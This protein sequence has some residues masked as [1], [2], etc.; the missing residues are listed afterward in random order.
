MTAIAFQSMTLQDCSRRFMAR[1]SVYA[2]HWLRFI[3]NMQRA[4]DMGFVCSVCLSIFCEVKHLSWP[5]IISVLVIY[6]LLACLL[7]F[8][9][10]ITIERDSSMC[11]KGVRCVHLMHEALHAEAMLLRAECP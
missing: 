5:P 9:K 10:C 8:S 1:V 2:V 4:I 7:N 3:A 11:A 6:L